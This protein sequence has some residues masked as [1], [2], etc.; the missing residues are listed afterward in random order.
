MKKLG[1]LFAQDTSS[2]LTGQ[3]DIGLTTTSAKLYPAYANV[4]KVFYITIATFYWVN[5][6]ERSKA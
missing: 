1:Q 3:F 2:T 6:L 5:S 4:L